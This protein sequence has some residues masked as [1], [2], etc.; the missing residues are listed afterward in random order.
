M[1]ANAAGLGKLSVTSALGQPLAAEIELFAADK[2]ELD[3]LRASLASDQAFHDAHV[4]FAPVLSYLRFPVEKKPNGKAVLKI[5]SSRP[6]NDP[7]VD[8][9][10]ELNWGSGRLVREYTM[11]L[12]PPGLAAKQTVAPVAA[13]APSQAP[14]AKAVPTPATAPQAQAK[15]AP[16]A[17][18]TAAPAPAG[19]PAPSDRVLV[20]RGDTLVGIAGRVRPEGVSLEQTLVGLYRENAKAF[21]GNMNRLKAGKTLD[22]R[23]PK[24][25]LPITAKGSGA[26]TQVAGG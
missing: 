19:K 4:E 16:V 21:D 5:S 23:R 8:M 14:A 12:D 20:K 9:L 17:P 26:R 1:M 10:V 24:K 25:S 13:V 7:F 3:S 22:S 2:A 15:P 6:V 11:L 18:K